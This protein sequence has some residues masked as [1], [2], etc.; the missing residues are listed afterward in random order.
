MQFSLRGDGQKKGEDGSGEEQ[1]LL[2]F[3]KK[4]VCEGP[5]PLEDHCLLGGIKVQVP[6]SAADPRHG[7]TSCHHPS[8]SLDA[9]RILGPSMERVDEYPQ[10]RQAAGYAEGGMSQKNDVTG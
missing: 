6:I 8:S 1:V 4:I 10:C 7:H 3:H 2:R 5:W 9:A